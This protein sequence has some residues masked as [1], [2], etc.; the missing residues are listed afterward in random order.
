MAVPGKSFERAVYEFYKQL[1]P[2]ADVRFD[3]RVPD[4]YGGTLRQADVWV[5][6]RIFGNLSVTILISCKDHA[7]PL[8]I[9]AIDSLMSEMAAMGATNGVLYSRSGF[10]K[11]AI[12]K[13]REL[14]ISCCMLFADAPPELPSEL[15][16]EAFF[17]NPCYRML[18]TTRA[19][20]PPADLC[21]RSVTWGT[22]DLGGQ[23][24]GFG[25]VITYYCA[26]FLAQSLG[27]QSIGE[28]VPGKWGEG[29][30]SVPWPASSKWP[31]FRLEL[32]FVWE[33][34]RGRLNAYRLNGSLNVGDRGFVGSASLPPISLF[35]PPDAASWEP[36][37]PPPPDLPLIRMV[38]TGFGL[39]TPSI[40]RLSMA[41][42]RV[43]SGRTWSFGS[44]VGSEIAD[45]V[46]REILRAMHAHAAL[47]ITANFKP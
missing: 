25:E 3:H 29:T 42:E 43:F 22:A 33:W 24:V 18:V 28:A 4:R 44:A 13:A 26:A 38:V 27:P 15:V 46:E 16:V 10:T 2:H 47:T 21:W 40:V 1:D 9:T 14:K 35:A 32:A 31:E 45:V 30:A 7:R 8:D 19:S 20:D 17:A 34:F 36:S 6:H 37:G 5:T 11:S 23:S 41:D 39:P 12:T